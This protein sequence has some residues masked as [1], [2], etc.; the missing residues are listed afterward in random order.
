LIPERIH[1]CGELGFGFGIVRTVRV[2]FLSERVRRLRGSFFIKGDS[3]LCRTIR[4]AF[5]LIDPS[6]TDANFLRVFQA[7][8]CYLI[9]LCGYPVDQLSRAE[10]RAACMDSE[11]SLC[12]TLQELR[13]EAIAIVLHS[14]RHNVD[15]AIACAG[16]NGQFLD[17]P[18]PGRWWRHREI[19]LAE[20]VPVLRTFVSIQDFRAEMQQSEE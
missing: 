14:I 6:I 15:R 11:P 3:G 18:Y 16:W 13:P 20:L 5:R 10:R 9:D 8:G 1:C 2:C 19:F 4:D 7:A 17:L 12:R